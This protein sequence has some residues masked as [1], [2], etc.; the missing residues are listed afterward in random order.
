VSATVRY[1]L[2]NW[3]MHKGQAEAEAWTRRVA[4]ALG[5]KPGRVAAVMPTFTALGA[6]AALCGEGLALGAQDVYP[7]ASGAVTGEVG[8]DQLRDLGVRYVL[9]GHSE[10]RHLLGEDDNLVAAKVQAVLDAGMTPVVCVGENA[11]E[12]EHGRADAVVRRQVSGALEGVT[13]ERLPAI[14]WAYEPVWAI[15]SG[16][17]AMPEQA[18]EAADILRH[19]LRSRLGADLDPRAVSVLYG[20]SV[21]PENVAEYANAPGV[22]GALV[23]GASLDAGAFL[24]LVAAV[25]G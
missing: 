7:A 1:V 12:R 17:P 9:C 22:D 21:A 13:T 8:T 20:G 16:H 18:S 14:V 2:A 23:G 3:K 24:E 25:E 10:R 5:P 4:A 15:G 19:A 6:V 11:D